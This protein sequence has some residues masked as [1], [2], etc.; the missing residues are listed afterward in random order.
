[1]LKS[2]S[3]GAGPRKFGR[4]ITPRPRQSDDA[5]RVYE[6]DGQLESYSNS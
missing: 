4:R 3:G 5:L 2:R 6:R 1:M